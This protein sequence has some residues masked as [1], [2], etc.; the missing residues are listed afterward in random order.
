MRSIAAVLVAV[1]VSLGLGCQ[2]DWLAGP[3][4]SNEDLV[5]K[6]NAMVPQDGVN[7]IAQDPSAFLNCETFLCLSTN[8]SKPYCTQ[9]C[10]TD[11]ECKNGNEI[12]M[13]CKVVTQ[14]GPLACRMPAH[15]HCPEGADPEA[16][17][18][19][20]EAGTNAV[21]EPASYCAAKDGEVPHDPKALTA[22]GGTEG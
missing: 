8:G 17:C 21:V 11:T 1:G 3:C 19:E 13:E 4:N 6:D 14:F 20:K 18:C 22:G 16:L 12:G 7:Y 9:R 2:A 5:Y 10:V 15:E